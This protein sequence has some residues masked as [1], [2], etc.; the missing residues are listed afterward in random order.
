MGGRFALSCMVRRIYV[1]A[2]R[3]GKRMIR[4]TQIFAG[5]SHASQLIQSAWYGK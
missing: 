5:D 1:E 2:L 3:D 4:K